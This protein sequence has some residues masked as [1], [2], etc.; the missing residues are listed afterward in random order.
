M[1]VCSV[2]SVDIDMLAQ[3]RPVMNTVENILCNIGIMFVCAPI[4]HS[5]DAR[6]KLELLHKTLYKRNVYEALAQTSII[7]KTGHFAV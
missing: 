4:A 3:E 7:V 5:F 2:L 6:C 1:V